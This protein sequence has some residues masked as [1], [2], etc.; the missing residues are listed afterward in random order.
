[1][2]EDLVAEFIAEYQAEWN[3]LQAERRVSATR[4]D[5]KLAEVN[6]RISGIVDAIERGI[7]TP[8]T[9]QRLEALEAE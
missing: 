6:R 3:R 1:M 5:R 9:K 8:T 4:R 2:R 7:I